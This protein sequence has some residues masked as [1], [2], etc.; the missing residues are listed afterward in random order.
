MRGHVIGLLSAVGL[1]IGLSAANVSG[2]YGADTVEA[3]VAAARA[4][5]GQGH[6]EM[7]PLC[8]PPVPSRG[9]PPATEQRQGPPDRSQWYVEP[10]KVFGSLYFVGQKRVSAWAGHH[11]GRDYP[12][13][14]DLRLLG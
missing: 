11:I 9:Q 3:H 4:A 1:V 8:N 10:V 6:T 2:Q 5:A 14:H 13:R 12:S 7:L